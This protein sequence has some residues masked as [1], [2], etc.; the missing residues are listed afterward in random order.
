MEIWV[1]TAAK[2]AAML[3]VA[4]PRVWATATAVSVVLLSAL[5]AA[6]VV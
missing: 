2:S 4:V 5:T 6:V 3:P 1:M